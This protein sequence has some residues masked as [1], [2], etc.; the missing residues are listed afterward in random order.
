MNEINRIKPDTVVVVGA[1]IVG[2]CV[3]YYVRKAGFE[4]KVIDP[5][6][7]GSQCTFGNAGSISSGAV[8]PLSMPGSLKSALGMLLEPT[9]PLYLPLGYLVKAAPWL[10]KFVAASKPERVVE[11]AAALHGLLKNAMQMHQELAQEIGCS[12]LLKDNGQLQLYPNRLALQK[13]GA[14]W[15]LKRAYGL[16]TCEIGGAEIRKMEPAVSNQYDCGYFLPDQGWVAEPFLYASAIAAALRQQGVEFVRDK[17]VNMAPA[18]NG[19]WT[20]DTGSGSHSAR[21]VV[22]AAGAWSAQLLRLLGIKIPLESQRGYHVQFANPNIDISRT[23]VLADRKVFITPM[24]CGLRAAGTV[25]FGGLERPPSASRANLLA[26]HVKAG[27]P[28]LDVSAATT[29]MGHRPCLPDSMPVIGAM[30]GHAGLWSAFGHG[31]LGITGSVHTGRLIAD[32]IGGQPNTGL[33][34]AFSASRFISL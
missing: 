18:G 16:E 31:H 17:V 1:G 19:E 15:D 32:A 11:I 25:E 30:P 28:G 12:G 7:P 21:H 27:L 10:Q 34:D 2:L 8:A 3:A 6:E 23:V 24:D 4:V 5:E 9:G 26:E 29:W 33:L 22:V 13:D 20:V 14:S